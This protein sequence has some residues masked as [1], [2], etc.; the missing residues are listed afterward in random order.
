MTAI[1]AA[2]VM[3]GA[4]VAGAAMTA[5]GQIS[6]AQ[7]Q[8]AMAGYNAGVE[9]NRAMEAEAVAESDATD[10]RRKGGLANAEATATAGA[11]GLIPTEG[12]PYEVMLGNAANTELEAQRRLFTGRLQAQG[13]LS[14]AALDQSQT[15]PTGG[16]IQAGAGLLSSGA[17]AYG[18]LKTPSTGSSPDTGPGTG[19]TY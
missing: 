16:Y 11:A 5:Y 17:K 19:Y 6:N 8:S 12:S 15:N 18:L 14:Q 3:A 13:S 7:N 9:R 2:T 10:I 4:A 1:T